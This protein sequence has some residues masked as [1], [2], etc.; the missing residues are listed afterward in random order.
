MFTTPQWAT[1]FW[2]KIQSTGGSCLL[3][4]SNWLHCRPRTSSHTVMLLGGV[5]LHHLLHHRQQ[6]M[7]SPLGHLLN[8]QEVAQQGRWWTQRVWGWV[9]WSTKFEMF[10][11]CLCLLTIGNMFW[12]GVFFLLVDGWWIKE[13]NL[14]QLQLLLVQEHQNL[15]IKDGGGKIVSV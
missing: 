12:G 11:V 13:A 4:C 2:N 10:L 15:G 6:L 9:T 3:W 8:Q 14:S 5:I 7:V 1:H